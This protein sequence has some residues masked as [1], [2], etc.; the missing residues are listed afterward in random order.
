MTDVEK[1][2]LR[3]AIDGPAGAG[4]STVA[5]RLAERLGYLLVDTGAIYRTVALAAMR[6]GIAAS[7]QG[8]IGRLAERLVAERA[9]QLERAVSGAEASGSGMRVI[10]RG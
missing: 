3:V 9:I 4:K 7:N 1:R 8:A 10:L 2:R 6:E 5:R